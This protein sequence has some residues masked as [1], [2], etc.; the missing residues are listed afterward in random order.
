MKQKLAIIGT[1]IAGMSAAHFLK[2]EYEL[3]IFEKDNYVGGHTHTINVNHN[4]NN[5]VKF[6]TGFMVFNEQT[7]PNLCQLFQQLGVTYENTDMS[8]ANRHDVLNWEYNGSSLNGIFAQ[9]K[10]IFNPK[11]IQMILEINRFNSVG[12]ALL[13][14]DK[15][16]ETETLHEFCVRHNFG[17][18][19]KDCY[20]IPMAG[21]VWSTPHEKMNEFPIATLIRFFKNHGFLGLSTQYQWKTV[22][23]G[24]WQYR[25][26]LIAPFLNLIK[27][28]VAVSAIKINSN[29]NGKKFQIIHQHGLEEFDKVVVAC[30]G[31]QAAL[32]LKDSEEQVRDLLA[33]Y[34]YQPNWAIVHQDESVM[35]KLRK[36]WASW[37]T[38][39]RM[40]THNKID[41]YTVYYMNRLQ[42][43]KTDQQYFI[44]INGE[45]FIDPKKIIKKILYHHPLYSTEAVQN[46]PKLHQLNERSN[47]LYFCGG[48]FRYGFHEDGIWSAI[49]MVKRM[50]P[51]GWQP[52]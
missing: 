17:K 39:S 14:T 23:G 42:N 30:H 25:D 50:R 51:Q 13:G 22:T 45:E 18:N 2:D 41:H 21:A 24:S 28:N 33:L 46:W 27:T 40:D 44:N 20:L 26:K 1:G 49:E 12:P 37:C 43:L 47:G 7:Y 38:L 36:N 9:R 19:F 5:G 16:L 15:K 3:T 48:Y 35:P 34:E 6:D 11:F 29:N 32:L 4:L 52:W 10:N 31:D 8:F